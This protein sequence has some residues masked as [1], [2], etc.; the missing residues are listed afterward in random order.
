MSSPALPQ[1]MDRLDPL[2]NHVLNV[3]LLSMNLAAASNFSEEQVIQ[4]GMGALLHDVG[5]LLV[6]KVIRDK[7]GRLSDEEWYEIRKH[8][9]FGIHIIDR[10]MRLP[11]AVKYITYQTHERENGKGYPKQR[12][13]RLIH[14]YAKI[15]QI[16]DIF[17]AVSSPRPY[18][19]AYTPYKGVEMLIKM[20]KQ[21]L[22]SEVY[23]NTML[24]S[25]SL[26]P[27]GSMVEISDGRLAQVIAA[28]EYHLGRPLLSVVSENGGKV[29]AP[30]NTYSLDLTLEPTIQVVRSLPFD[31]LGCDV[32]YGF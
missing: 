24:K 14:N 18:R 4:I 10:M 21:K 16:A 20:G 23:V 25:I 7:E 29:L 19:I 3:A 31:A 9:L 1:K 2:Y 27:V 32:L 17:D 13:G 11:D 8:P 30:S 6:P 15:V 5:M 26:F 12:S 22:I 28:N